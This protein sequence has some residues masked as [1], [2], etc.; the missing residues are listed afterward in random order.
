MS[1]R[2]VMLS[3]TYDVD[4][5]QVSHFLNGQPISK[6]PIKDENLVEQID[7]G[8]SSICNW[9]KPEPMYRTDSEFVVRNLNGSMD[10]FSIY[11]GALSGNEIK[12]LYQLGKP[13]EQ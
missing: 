2:W 6:E 5:K 3:V 10:E 8:V 4:N 13:N 7:I 12:D 11:S 1:G 9:G